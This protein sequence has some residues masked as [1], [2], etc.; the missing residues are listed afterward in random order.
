MQQ[1]TSARIRI[2]LGPLGA[3]CNIETDSFGGIDVNGDLFRLSF[4]ISQNI[5]K[6]GFSNRN[7]SNNVLGKRK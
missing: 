1:I 3:D 7:I 6:P 2:R 4:K 5:I